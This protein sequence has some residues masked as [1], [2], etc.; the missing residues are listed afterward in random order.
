MSPPPRRGRLRIYLGAAP[1]VGKTVAM[2]DEGWRR[3]ERG[4]DVVV[5]WIEDHG[6]AETRARVRDLEVLPR[7]TITHRGVAFTEMDLDALL[8]RAPEVALVDEYAHT[9]VP[10]SAHAKRWEDVEALLDA[11]I[12]VISTV[13]V[14]HLESLND[15]VEAITGVAQR[16]TVPDA[17]V[18]AAD[19]VELV[20]MTPEA[21]RRRMAHGNVYAADKV[22][23]ALA[24]Y[25]REGNLGALRELALLWVADRVDE[26]L[27]AYRERHG[28]AAAWEARE[29]VMVALTGAPGGDRLVRRAARIAGRLKA[30]LVGVHVRRSD[31][32]SS[33]SEVKLEQD[34][35][36]LADLGGRF[37]ETTGDDVAEAL[38]RTAR[39][40]DVTQVVLGASRRS[41]W[42]ELTEG[43]VVNKVLRISG[44]VDVHVISTDEAD[45][46]DRPPTPAAGRAR[47]GALFPRRR[48]TVAYGLSLLGPVLLTLV[49]LPFRG[50]I[51]LSTVLLLLLSLVVAVAGIGGTGP[52]VVAAVAGTLL[53]NWFFTPPYGTVTISDPENLL[54]LGIL[55]AVGITVA[56][57][58]ERA[59]RRRVEAEAARAEA[60]ELAQ[61][62]RLGEAEAD[63]LATAN[64]LRTALLRAV[65]HDLR[66]PL[67]SM[68]ASVTSL[69]QDDVAWSDEDTR[70]FLETIDT[71]ADRLDRLVGELLDMG[72]IEAGAVEVALT[73]VS[74]DELLAGALDGAGATPDRIRLEVPDDLP[75]VVVDPPLVERALANVLANALRH[76]PPD[77]P[78]RVEAAGL[79]D[80]VVV[81]VVDTG[82][83]IRPDQRE[84][85]LQPFQRLGDGRADPGVGLGLAVARGFTEAVGGRLDLDDTPGGGLTVTLTLPRRPGGE[86]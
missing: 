27:I 51:N 13:N 79:G 32:L 18:R 34:K 73:P 12:D 17:V 54:S 41:R 31:G 58:L 14:Q 76:A 84:R 43:S 33:G 82:P 40:E 48:R 8:A 75:G 29:R 22:D 67:A 81:R 46:A 4:T 80:D 28:I 2:L 70:T 16:E 5:G 49:L 59:L 10:G 71:E 52:A 30:P 9:N 55:A 83:G 85:V 37:V 65:S 56:A 66:T 19:Q 35:K 50:E 26:S 24:N 36:L 7:R 21:L 6:R 20:D 15:T 74:V 45:A 61:E 47:G 57:L 68:K 23:A 63:R 39:Q 53:V 42:A 78:V 11:G 86:S 60:A 64:A 62:L 1:G 69:M 25:F 44:P 3:R 38:V 72:R 77:T